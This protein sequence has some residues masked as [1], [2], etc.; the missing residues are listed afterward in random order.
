MCAMD[1]HPPVGRKAQQ[2]SFRDCRLEMIMRINKR[3]SFSCRF[4]R[5]DRKLLCQA[6]Y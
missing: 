4:K 6:E 2:N 5:L 3:Y 1:K